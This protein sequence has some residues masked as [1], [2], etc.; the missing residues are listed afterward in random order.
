MVEVSDIINLAMINS[1]DNRKTV[2]RV[3]VATTWALVVVF[4]YQ[5]WVRPPTV[6]NN[7]PVYSNEAATGSDLWQSGVGGV[8]LQGTSGVDQGAT[9]SDFQGGASLLEGSNANLF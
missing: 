2:M 1:K 9:G 5:F 3:L 4:G 8:E 7:L 6:A